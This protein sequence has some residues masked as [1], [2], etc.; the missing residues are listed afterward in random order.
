MTTN[1]SKKV[2]I[3]FVMK[4][5][6]AMKKSGQG[7]RDSLVFETITITKRKSRMY[8]CK[9]G[10]CNEVFYD[11]T[12]GKRHTRESHKLGQ[13]K[14]AVCGQSTT[15]SE[16]YKK[17]ME[18]HEKKKNKWKCDIC[19]KTFSH[20]CYLDMHVLIHTKEKKYEC[21]HAE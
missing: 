17:H 16:K 4:D 7:R 10:G 15:T 11:I 18:V 13:Y 2:D 5:S 9:Q 3:K 19:E 8:K 1:N 20:K 21:S 14:C 12:E 6:S